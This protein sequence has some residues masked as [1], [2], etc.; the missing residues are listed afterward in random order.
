MITTAI[1]QT[2]FNCSGSPLAESVLLTEVRLNLG[3][4][5]EREFQSGLARLRL[6]NWATSKQDELTGDTLWS[7]TKKGAARMNP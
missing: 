4:C 6:D 7:I 1:L 5:G 2:L 3:K